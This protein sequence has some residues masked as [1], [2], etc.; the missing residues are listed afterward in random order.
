MVPQPL[1]ASGNRSYLD[2]WVVTSD[3]W[4]PGYK[5]LKVAL[6]PSVEWVAGAVY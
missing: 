3:P 6:E 5:T 2:F 1:A 4:Y